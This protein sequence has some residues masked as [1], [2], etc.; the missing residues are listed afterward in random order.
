MIFSETTTLIFSLIC[1]YILGAMSMWAYY[2][3]KELTNEE[4]YNDEAEQI[5]IPEEE[6]L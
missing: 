2:R 1:A 4:Y 6:E 3:R 5:I